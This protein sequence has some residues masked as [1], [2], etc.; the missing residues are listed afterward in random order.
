MLLFT[1]SPAPAPPAILPH[2]GCRPPKRTKVRAAVYLRLGVNARLSKP[3]RTLGAQDK[4]IMVFVLRLVGLNGVGGIVLSGQSGLLKWA[5]LAI[6]EAIFSF[7]LSNESYIVTRRSTAMVNC[8]E[9]HRVLIL[10]ADSA[11]KKL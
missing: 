6:R 3:R 4:L 9:P 5:E 11:G 7:G 10:L 8:A 1:A 2:R